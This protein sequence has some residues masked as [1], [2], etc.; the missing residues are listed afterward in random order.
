MTPTEQQITCVESLS[1]NDLIKID[2]V[3]GSGKTSTLVMISEQYKQHSL[4]CAFNKVTATEASQKFGNHVVCQTTHSM[5][6][7]VFGGLLRHKLAR[8]VGG[9]VNVAG[10]GSEI[11][12]YYKMM[13]GTLTKAQLGMF[14]KNT[15]AA[16]EQSAD[17]FITMDHVDEYSITKAIKRLSG[18]DDLNKVE[19]KLLTYTSKLVFDTAKSLWSARIDPKSKVLATHD[20][21]LKLYQLSKPVLGYQIV[22][23]DEAADTTPCVLDIVMRQ[24]E[25]AKV[26]LVGDDRQAIYQWRGAVN[27]MSLIH[28]LTLPLSQSF[29]YG[30]EI[31]DVAMAVLGNTTKVIGNPAI[32]SKAARGIIDTTKPYTRLFRTNS[33]LLSEAVA[34]LSRGESL[35]IEIDT[36]DFIKMLTSAMAL[37][38]N[39]L[40]NVKHERIMPFAKWEDMIEEGQYDR[41]IGR[42]VK[43]IKDGKAQNIINVLTNYKPPLNALI[44]MTTAH[45]SKGREWKQVRL[46]DDFPSHLK[47]NTKDKTITWVGLSESEQNILYV[48]VTR[49]IDFLEI[50]TS[51]Q[52]AIDFQNGKYDDDQQAQWSEDEYQQL[53]STN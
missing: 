5:A 31:A 20:T 32:K 49:A 21:Y 44:T 4:Y 26:V 28:G 14:V 17:D 19:L 35:N 53:L 51:V 27:A 52:E 22:Y 24:Q 45:K 48:A 33:H 18:R 41:E 30:Q 23:L 40:N 12:K 43:I 8:P 9:Y 13:A 29:R 15:V 6:Y 16:F 7:A 2:A 25:T 11:G 37:H 34:A 10:T 39:D 36:K 3:A 38:G 47:G 1:T 46:E 50:N 42:L